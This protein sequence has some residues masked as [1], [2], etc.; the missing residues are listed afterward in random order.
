MFTNYQEENKQ[1]FYNNNYQTTPSIL[2]SMTEAIRRLNEYNY[3]EQETNRYLLNYLVSRM[4]Q[5]NLSILNMCQATIDQ[6]T[7]NIYQN[8][9]NLSMIDQFRRSQN[10]FVNQDFSKIEQKENLAVS[11][12]D[13]STKKHDSSMESSLEMEHQKSSQIYF[14]FDNLP[15]ITIGKFY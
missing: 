13:L 4:N 8:N 3:R 2:T 14:D 10:S 6:F 9:M 5:P 11:P 1:L 15:D 12:H 7:S